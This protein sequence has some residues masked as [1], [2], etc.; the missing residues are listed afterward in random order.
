MK[1]FNLIVGIVVI[2]GVLTG[3]AVAGA[4]AKLDRKVKPVPTATPTVGTPK[5]ERATLKNGLEVWVVQR[6]E[7]P[8]VTAVLQIRSGSS[9]DGAQPGIAA[10]TASLLDEGT[11]KRNAI[12]FA[13]AQDLLGATLSASAFAEQ[14]QVTLQTLSKNLGP[15]LGLLGEMVAQPAFKADEL[16][17]ERKTRLQGLKQQKDVAS[18]VADRVFNIVAYGQEHPYGRPASGTQASVAAITRDDVVSFYERYYRP[19]N[20]V[21]FVVGDVTLQQL[22]PQLEQGLAGWESKPLP[23]DAAAVP[24]RPAAKPM[25]VYLVDKPGAAQSEIRIG[26]PAAART[27]NP[28]YYALQVAM[29]ALGGQFT[30]RVNLNLR[31]RHGFTYGARSSITYRRGAGPLMASAGVFTA[32]T[33]SSLTEFLRELKDIRGSR[34]LSP[35]E[36]EAA[37]NALVRG[38]PRRFETAEATIG[39]LGDLA[40]YGLPDTEISNFLTQVGKVKP[41]DVTRVASQYITPENLAVVVVGD[42]AKVRPG[43]EALN[44]GPI[45]VLDSDGK[46]VVAQ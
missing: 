12:D 36:T 34:P 15:A 38:Y 27:V 7:L 31:E 26:H 24:E 13:V 17:R 14:S 44:L 46:P 37:R 30:S 1:T 33:D 4:A 18:S 6:H 43:I 19:N 5:I 39:V 45:S 29:T 32:K 40:L 35:E 8:M 28:D 10:M 2:V 41:E 3:T 25:A 21:L 11:A 9:V 42:L 22:V 23:A 20:S 16:E